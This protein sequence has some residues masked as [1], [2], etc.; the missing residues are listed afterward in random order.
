MKVRGTH[1]LEAPREDVFRAICDPKTLM[2]VIPGCDAVE[3]VSADEYRGRLTLRLPGFAGSFRTNVRLVDA[4]PP[5][6]A[7]LEGGVEGPFGSI[8]GRAEFALTSA[9]GA[10]V[11]DYHGEALI[12]GPLARIDSRFAESLAE[13]LIAQGL[14]ALNHRLTHTPPDAADFGE[15]RR[16]TEVSE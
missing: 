16:S 8:R 10:T 13:S 7:G 1:A 14:R 11:I 2:A 5:E 9:A 12:D 6:R 4:V 3:Q 15:R